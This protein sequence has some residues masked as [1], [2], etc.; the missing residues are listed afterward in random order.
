M[1]E[2]DSLLRELVEESGDPLARLLSR[3]PSVVVTAFDHSWLFYHT[4]SVLKF[5]KKI[6]EEKG[7]PERVVKLVELSAWLHDIGYVEDAKRHREVGAAAVEKVLT[8]AGLPFSEVG[9]VV[10]GIRNHGTDDVPK[11]DVG[12]I[13]RLAD[14]LAV[15][16]PQFVGAFVEDLFD[17]GERAK[18]RRLL[19][20]KW[21]VIEEYGAQG[22]V[23]KKMVEKLLKFGEGQG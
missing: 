21:R 23:R 11:T 1:V 3:V 16:D 19:D 22:Y 7:L 5:A 13:I 18:F 12:H 6:A 8:K 17:E 4:L 14:A 10:D 20:K 2:L 9:I 15:W